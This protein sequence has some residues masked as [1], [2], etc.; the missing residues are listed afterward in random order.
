MGSSC[1]VDFYV[2]QDDK[3]S[4]EQLACHLAMMAW[5]QGMRSLVV[6]NSREQ[7]AEMDQLMW[8]LPNGRFLPHQCGQFEGSAPVTI[9]TSQDLE[10]AQTEVIINLD[11]QAV[12]RPE[13]FKRLLELVPARDADRKAS[14][15]KF[16]AYREIGL[17]PVSHN[18]NNR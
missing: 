6:A 10:S 18:M 9:G 13:R 14:R 2:L 7:A 8:S 17:D 4:V 5:E 11:T 15:I 1:Q 3:K 16:K 12:T